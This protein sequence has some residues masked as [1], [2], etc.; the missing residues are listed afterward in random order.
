MLKA[1]H[2][3]GNVM[4]NL[5]VYKD[6][7]LKLPIFQALHSLSEGYPDLQEML[8]DILSPSEALSLGKEI[9]IQHCQRTDLKKFF[10]K[11]RSAFSNQVCSPP[12]ILVSNIFQWVVMP[13]IAPPLVSIEITRIV[14]S[15]FECT[16]VSQPARG[17]KSNTKGASNSLAQK[18]RHNWRVEGI[19]QQNFQV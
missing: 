19:R 18:G 13:V 1:T 8:L 12:E 4:V 7:T 9:Y 5:G 6:Q 10:Q 2:V 11:V 15:S 16:P 14:R 17:P 3:F